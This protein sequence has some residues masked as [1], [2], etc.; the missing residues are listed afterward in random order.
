M[1]VFGYR[2]Y[3]AYLAAY[4]ERQRARKGGFTYAD[5]AARAG[6][7]SSNYLKLVIDGARNLSSDMAVRFGEQ[8]GLRGEP[9][10]FFCALVA[11]NQAKTARE[12]EVHYSKLQ[13]FRRFRATHRLDAAESAYH[14]QWFIPAVRELCARP[15]FDADPQWIA[16]TLVPAISPRQASQAL[17]VLEQ[18][19]MIVRD[20]DGRYGQA[21]SVVA[22]PQGPLG[23]HVVRF[24]REMMHRAAE[25]MDLVPREEREIAGLTLCLSDARMRELKGELERFRAHLLDR[26]MT[27]EAPERVVQ[28]NFQMFPLSKKKD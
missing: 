10:S 1:D 22:T 12:R 4:Y 20:E 23:H 6:L 13:S 8:C 14:S 26:Y 3:R 2:D 16:S 19:G 5:F 24:H 21:E 11:F 18:L 7:R 25:S 27:D 9:L 28:V 17:K 15:D